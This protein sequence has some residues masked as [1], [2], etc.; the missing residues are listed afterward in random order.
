MTT[1]PLTSGA[2]SVPGLLP[3]AQRCVNLYPETTPSQTN[4]PSP[5]THKLAPGLVALAVFPNATT[6]RGL[7]RATN[8]ELFGVC[9][10]SAYFIAQVN[11]SWNFTFLGTLAPGT[12][13][14]RF[15]D[16]GTDRLIADGSTIGYQV[17][18]SSHVMTGVTAA[19]ASGTNGFVYY[20]ANNIS[21][22]DGYIIGNQPGTA[23]WWATAMA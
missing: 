6:V 7:Y 5:V 20:G 4:P 22:I 1:L 9:G 2:Y 17:N 16:N 13:P 18:L 11:G 3:G 21:F 23:N 15:S 12:N 19:N 10:N 14:V 8:N